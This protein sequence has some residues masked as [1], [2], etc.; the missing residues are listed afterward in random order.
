MAKV[1]P[2]DKGFKLIATNHLEMASI[3]SYGICDSCNDNPKE[4]VY[5][6]VLNY[7]MC[8]ECFN[9]WHERAVYYPQDAK[10]ENRNFK[11]Y[12]ELFKIRSS[13]PVEE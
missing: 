11:V 10:Y 8:N 3:G 4:G 6:A 9:K 2:S 13:E 1:L 5:V 7:W 12:G